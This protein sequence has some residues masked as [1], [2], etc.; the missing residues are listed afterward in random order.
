[1]I[2]FTSS[3]VVTKGVTKKKLHIAIVVSHPIQHFCP[4]YVSF[5]KIEGI[6]CKVFF[7]ST[8]GFKKYIDPSFNQE[9][10]WDNLHLDQFEHVFMN[11]ETMIPIDK[12]ID[13]ITA[14]HD[15]ENFN[16]DLVIIYGYWQKLQ[17]RVH[18]W[19]ITKG[20]KIAYIS[21]TELRHKRNPVK[22]K[23][24]EMFIRQYFA[25]IKYFLSIGDANEEFYIRNGVTANQIIRMHL[26]IDVN[27]YKIQYEK[28][29]ILRS[30][31]RNKYF[32]NKNEIVISVVGKLVSWKNQD[33]ILETLK[34]LE[35]DNICIHLFIIGSGI[36]EDSWKQKAKSLKI[37]KVY[38][39]GFINIQELPSYYA[40]TDIYIHPASKEPHS[41]AISEAIFM[42]CA[43]LVSDRCGSYGESDDVQ[44]G[45]NG[46]VFSFG[47]LQDL[48]SKMK[49]LIKNEGLRKQLGEYSHTLAVKF[50]ESAHYLGLDELIKKLNCGHKI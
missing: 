1:M 43:I 9:V 18:K 3:D 46:F 19:A 45:K 12:K 15:L 5:S 35:K 24:M 36:M 23:L 16:P 14:G 10:I 27:E 38:F 17:R 48:K 40:A 39:T 37:S 31:V 28:R 41:I 7:A 33:H 4:Q 2:D 34:L 42:G 32:I 21:D 22:K 8:Q 6:R 26:P 25:G 30:D 47:N 49:M 44:E 20:V 50:Q 11:G 29:D 13:A